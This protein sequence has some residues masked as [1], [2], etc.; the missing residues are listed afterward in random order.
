M[1]VILNKN[2][3]NLRHNLSVSTSW[4]PKVITITLIIICLVSLVREVSQLPIGRFSIS[5]PNPEFLLPSF[6]G[7][8]GFF[9]GYSFFGY[10]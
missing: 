10:P 7:M 3:H 1:C 2:S 5:Y 8:H 9:E 4:R 6:E